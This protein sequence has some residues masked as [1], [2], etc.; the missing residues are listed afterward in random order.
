MDINITRFFHDADAFEFSASQAERGKHAGAETW[1][2]AKAEGAES[3][4]L[5]TEEEID[6]LRFYVKDFGAWDDEEIAA[7]DSVECN[8][9]FIQLVSGDIRETGMFAGD[10]WDWAEYERGAE[11]GNW[12][13]NL[14]RAGDGKIYYSLQR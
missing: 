11:R 1:A 5:K 12:S 13:G 10:Q 7:W 6:A 2:N 14:Y 8:A 3:P 9:L 4:L